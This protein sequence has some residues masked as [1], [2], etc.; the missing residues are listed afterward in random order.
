MTASEEERWRRQRHRRHHSY[1]VNFNPVFFLLPSSVV[2]V[3]SCF[4]TPVKKGEERRN[5]AC[6]DADVCV[7]VADAREADD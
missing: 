6:V 2:S 3:L 4:L 5:N 7:Y 1:I